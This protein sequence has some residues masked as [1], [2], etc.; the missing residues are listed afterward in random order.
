MY[1]YNNVLGLHGIH[2]Q[3]VEV[4]GGAWI[5]LQP[6]E[7]PMLEPKGCCEPWET[8]TGAGSWQ[9]LWTM[10]KEA[11]IRTGLLAGLVTLQETHTGAVLPEGFHPV[12]RI[13][14]GVV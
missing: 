10:K 14:T 11:Q 8:H 4:H 7:D 9:D 12:E 5:H 2:L 6:M 13:H 3:P 1:I